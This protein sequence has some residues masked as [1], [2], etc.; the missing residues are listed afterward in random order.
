MLVLCQVMYVNLHCTCE[1]SGMTWRALQIHSIR[2]QSLNAFTQMVFHRD[3][4]T[5]NLTTSHACRLI[6]K[7]LSVQGASKVAACQDETN[8]LTHQQT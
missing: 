1:G 6:S 8:A 7:V 5:V 3:E 2:E 4:R